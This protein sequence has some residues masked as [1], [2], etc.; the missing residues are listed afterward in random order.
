[1]LKLVILLTL[2]IA[3]CGPAPSKPAS[4]YADQEQAVQAD[5]CKNGYSQGCDLEKAMATIRGENQ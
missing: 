2:A 1:M 5:R 4:Y 3:G